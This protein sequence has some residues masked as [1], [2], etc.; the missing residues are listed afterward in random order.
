MRECIVNYKTA[1]EKNG[2]IA[3]VPGGNSMWPTLKDGKQSV[4][5][6]KKTQRLKPL[7]V[8]L[9]ERE[10][11]EIILH[12]VVEVTELG[13]ITRGDSQSLFENVLED[14]VIG[15][16]TSFYR[17]KKCIDVNDEKYLKEVNIWYA[18]EKRRKRKIDRFN[19]RQQIKYKIKNIFKRLSGKRDV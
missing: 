9:F 5:V 15:V 12:R 1:L 16:M 2:V 14:K 11:G 17:G 3:F 13:Y 8:A 19:R 10:S 7:D 6:V 4:I 18:N